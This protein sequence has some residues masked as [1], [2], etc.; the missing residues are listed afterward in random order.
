M[1]RKIRHRT[2][3]GTKN[4]YDGRLDYGL[5]APWNLNENNL[6]VA[7]A[8]I[9]ATVGDTDTAIPLQI[10]DDG[11]PTTPDRDDDNDGSPYDFLFWDIDSTDSLG[12]TQ[13]VAIFRE[14]PAPNSPYTTTVP[15]S[16]SSEIKSL[17]IVIEDV[18][19][20]PVKQGVS[21]GRPIAETSADDIV[22]YSAVADD[23]IVGLEGADALLS[24][25]GNDMVD[26][27]SGNDRIIGNSGDDLLYGEAGDDSL[28]GLDGQDIL[29]GG[30]GND[31]AFGNEGDD[32]LY[33]GSGNDKLAG[34]SGADILIGGLGNDLYQLIS[35]TS[36]IIIEQSGEGID[37][38]E[39]E[40]SYTL[41]D[42]VE[43]LILRGVDAVVGNGN[44][45]D[46]VIEERPYSGSTG[47]IPVVNNTIAAG[48]G[49][50]IVNAG[51]G[52]DLIDGGAGNDQIGG[53]DG[54]D[55]LTGGSGADQFVFDSTSASFS[56]YGTDT[57]TDFQ[58]AE[59]D[60]LVATLRAFNNQ[61]GFSNLSVGQLPATQ[62]H[63]GTQAQTLD[64]RFIYDPA[65]GALFYDP[66]GTRTYTFSGSIPKTQ[67][68]KLAPGLP[69]TH[70]AIQIVERFVIPEIP[71]AANPPPTGT[72][73]PATGGDDRLF[74]S[75]GS[76]IFNLL[77]GNDVGSGQEGD[78]S[79]NGGSGQDFLNGGSGNDQL[80][81]QAASDRLFGEAGDDRLDGGSE[82]DTVYGGSGNDTLSGGGGQDR[83]NFYNPA[84]DGVDQITDFN[85]AEDTIGLYVGNSMGNT[86]G[87]TIG[88]S[89]VSGFANTGLAVNAILRIDQFHIG[90]NATTSNHRLIYN[91]GTGALLFDPDGTGA[92]APVQIAA[93]SPGLAL[94]RSNFFAFDDTRVYALESTTPTSDSI[95][96]TA[97]PDNLNGG[98]GNDTLNG[99]AGNDTLTGGAGND[100]LRGGP[101]K[102]T[103]LGLGGSDI[104]S[105]EAGSDRLEGGNGKD[106]LFGGRGGDKL[107]GGKGRDIFVLEPGPGRDR[108]EDF[109][110]GQ[111]RL[112]LLPD[113]RFRQL[114]IQQKGDNTL[115][116]L[117]N[118]PLALLIDVSA[119][120]ITKAD[121]VSVQPLL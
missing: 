97:G 64:H 20:A 18:N 5:P 42:N 49:N 69:L 58:L 47:P 63:L 38:V 21:T 35:D 45:L 57:I 99:Y 93:L 100:W 110:N 77:A 27:G 16:D 14:Q 88:N 87:N 8:D 50:D 37:V 55:T 59:G 67:I 113:L 3:R 90:P 103:L 31:Q 71:D 39:T 78:D 115:I 109:R 19:S 2:G 111:D 24:G 12:F 73:P 112:G 26:G 11:D 85:G 23:L 94:T 6:Y 17:V 29:Y 30:S 60:K 92:A 84:S 72:V 107:I 76:D 118:D 22:V 9:L 13:E 61:S 79:L 106:T 4:R 44:G 46:N 119:R 56:D 25:A 114:T 89:E 33:G 82:N 70:T 34:D 52:D 108:I 41:P 86:T 95:D 36:D 104:L 83:F 105:G 1:A 62:F 74:G 28:H 120:Q 10:R 98:A 51:E 75:E 68:A 91:S 40:L 7:D 15:L 101:G 80:A 66:D 117:G 65:T 116:R 48:G 121:F 81:G 43:R 102:D 54:N 96:G 32:I 53:L